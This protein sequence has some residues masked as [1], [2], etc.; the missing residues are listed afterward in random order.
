[1][2]KGDAQSLKQV[3]TTT[4]TKIVSEY[5]TQKKQEASETKHNAVEM[6]HLLNVLLN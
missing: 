2:R 5:L 3:T 6:L 4:P 1:M